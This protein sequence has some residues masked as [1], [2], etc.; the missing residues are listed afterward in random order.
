MLMKFIVICSG[1]ITIKSEV[2]YN[3]AAEEIL[4]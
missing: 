2:S 1:K 4:F 3:L